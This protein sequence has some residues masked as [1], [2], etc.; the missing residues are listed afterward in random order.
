[1]NY[2]KVWWK[3][4]SKHKFA[5]LNPVTIIKALSFIPYAGFVFMLILIVTNS[6]V[7]SDTDHDFTFLNLFSALQAVYIALLPFVIAFIII[8]IIK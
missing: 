8:S 5:K 3:Y 2:L 7:Y 1:M 4:Y 6:R